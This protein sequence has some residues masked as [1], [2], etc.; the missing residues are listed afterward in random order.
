M[1]YQIFYKSKTFFLYLYF[2]CNILSTEAH[3]FGNTEKRTDSTTVVLN[4]P[5]SLWIAFPSSNG[6]TYHTTNEGILFLF[7]QKKYLDKGIKYS[8]KIETS[9][10]IGRQDVGD[11]S[12]NWSDWSDQNPK[13]YFL[14]EGN[15]TI[16]VKI[17]SDS[18]PEH[19]AGSF[20]V[21]IAGIS[22]SDTHWWLPLVALVAVIAAFAGY[23]C[24]R[25]MKKKVPVSP[26][27]TEI[28]HLYEVPAPIIP[29]G[30]N[31]YNDLVEKGK[32]FFQKFNMVTVLFA[33]IEGFSEITDSMSPEVLLDELNS[34]FFY[35]DTIVGRYN[36]E[37]I[38]T[39][40]DAYMCAGGFPQK[41][42]TNPVEVVLV[43]LEVQNHLD[44]LRRQNPNVWSIRIGIHTGQVIAGMLGH[45][46]LSFDIWG[47]TVN[48]ASRLESSCKSGKINISETTYELVKDFFVCEYQ[49]KLQGNDD[50]SYYVNGIRPEFLEKNEDGYPVPAHDF[51]VRIQMLRLNDLEEYIEGMMANATPDLFFHNYKHTQDVYEQVELLGYSENVTMENMLLLKTAALLHDVGYVASYNDAQAMSEKITRE[52]LPLFQYD[53]QQVDMVCRLMKASHY[54]SKPSGIMEQIMH[55]ANLMYYGRADFITRMMNLFREQQEHQVPVLKTE[56]LHHQIKRLSNHRFYTRAAEKFILVPANQQIANAEGLLE[57]QTE[58]RL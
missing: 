52:T 17:R 27:V 29:N 34:F 53:P 21:S 46:K 16:S 30:P 43:A 57:N 45:K 44:R 26:V 19:L 56:W 1:N 37:K 40:G 47:H 23:F 24:G 36:I 12:L 18:I 58:P 39:M 8:F 32:P 31:E 28:P 22:K 38:K 11:K 13:K 48:V 51:F 20:P 14:P 10:L 49:G 55:D 35:F 41:N 5:C 4:T 50:A 6:T 3:A 7:E 25:R 2:I 33:D 42:H 15:Y 9:E 54:E